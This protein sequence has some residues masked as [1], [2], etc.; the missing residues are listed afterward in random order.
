MFSSKEE[1][2]NYLMPSVCQ[3][4][5][6]AFIYVISFKSHNNP[7]STDISKLLLSKLR[8]REIKLLCSMLLTILLHKRYIA[9]G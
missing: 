6:L 4:P 9:Q 8:F 5:A 1:K 2:K 7:I 3:D